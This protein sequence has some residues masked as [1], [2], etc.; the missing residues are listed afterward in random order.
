M[1]HSALEGVLVCP[2]ELFLY[3]LQAFNSLR[4]GVKFMQSL[5]VRISVQAVK[6]IKVS[7]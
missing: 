2:G 5:F 7:L 6:Q 4:R 1:E 3:D